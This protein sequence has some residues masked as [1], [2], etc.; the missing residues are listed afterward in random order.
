MFSGGLTETGSCISS[1]DLSK[2]W[3]ILSSLGLTDGSDNNTFE[4]NC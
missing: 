2:V 1:A 4:G 3:K